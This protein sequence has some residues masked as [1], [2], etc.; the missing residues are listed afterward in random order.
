MRPMRS[1]S[2]PTSIGASSRSSASWRT[3]EPPRADPS[4][5]SKPILQSC[6]SERSEESPYLPFVAPQIPPPE[7][8]CQAPR[9]VQKPSMSHH[10]D[11]IKN[12]ANMHLSY[13]PFGTLNVVD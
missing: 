7:N 8:P 1:F 5:L 4:K 11:K 13:V 10:P 12:P 6:H 9:P 2:S 3:S